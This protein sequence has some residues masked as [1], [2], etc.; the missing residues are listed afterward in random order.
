MKIVFVVEHF[1]P[2]LGG[3]EELFYNLSTSLAKKGF[4]VIVITTKHSRTLPSRETHR[5]IEIIRVN[6]LNRYLFTIIKRKF[7][8]VHL[9]VM[10]KLQQWYREVR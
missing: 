4:K 3:A 7:N 5:D 1:Y 6:C 10:L 8:P 9:V 2:Y